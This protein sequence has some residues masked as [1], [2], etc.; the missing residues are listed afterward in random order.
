MANPVRQ[1]CTCCG[2]PIRGEGVWLEL[3][4]RTDTYTSETVPPGRSQ[5]GFVF[6]PTCARRERRRHAQA[7]KYEHLRAM[8]RLADLAYYHANTEACT[9]AGPGRL[10]PGAWGRRYTDRREE[11]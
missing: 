1:Y 8:V 6:G 5:G 9:P 11:A 2:K 10:I 4:Q 3:D 7:L